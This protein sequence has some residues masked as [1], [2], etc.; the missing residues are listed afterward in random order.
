MTR[1][2]LSSQLLHLS[3]VLLIA[4]MR[5]VH[6]H[7]CF[8]S[9]LFLLFIIDKKHSMDI[10]HIIFIHSPAHGYLVCF[11]LVEIINNT[12][13]F[14]FSNTNKNFNCRA[15]SSQEIENFSNFQVGNMKIINRLSNTKTQ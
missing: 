6:P 7:Y 1:V 10:D 8:I 14:N 5:Q 2:L 9:N 15:L 4:R 11:Q 3:I 12:Y 13:Q